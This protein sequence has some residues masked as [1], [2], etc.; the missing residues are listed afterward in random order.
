MARLVVRG[1]AASANRLKG[2]R[3]DDRDPSSFDQGALAEGTRHE[4]EHTDDESMARE[5]AM[6]HLAE[7]P[8]YYRKLKELEKAG[9]PHPGLVLKPSTVDPRVKRWQR[10]SPDAPAE[11]QARRGTG[12]LGVTRQTMESVLGVLATRIGKRD[13][14]MRVSQFETTDSRGNPAEVF[15]VADDPRTPGATAEASVNTNGSVTIRLGVPAPLKGEGW[16]RVWRETTLEQREAIADAMINDPEVRERVL[17]TLAHEIAHAVDA[18]ANDWRASHGERGPYRAVVQQ[19]REGGQGRREARRAA[20]NTSVGGATAYYNTPTEIRATLAEFYQGLLGLNTL[21]PAAHQRQVIDRLRS[22]DWEA[23]V[24]T[25]RDDGTWAFVAA[26]KPTMGQRVLAMMAEQQGPWRRFTALLSR[27]EQDRMIRHV[28]GWMARLLD[29]EDMTKAGRLDRT[30]LVL[31]ASDKNPR[32]RRWQKPPGPANLGVAGSLHEARSKLFNRARGATDAWRLKGRAAWYGPGELLRSL[33]AIEAHGADLNE[34]SLLPPKGW[35]ARPG[36]TE[37]REA[38]VWTIALDRLGLHPGQ[39]HSAAALKMRLQAYLASGRHPTAW[40]TN[41]ARRGKS[42]AHPRRSYVDPDPP[43]WTPQDLRLYHV[44]TPS[45]ARRIEREG[46][47]PGS[48]ATRSDAGGWGPTPLRHG[49]YLTTDPGDILAEIRSDMMHDAPDDAEPVIF[50]VDPEAL[51]TPSAWASDEDYAY[52]IAGQDPKPGQFPEPPWARSLI[53]GGTMAYLGRIHPRHLRRIGTD[54]NPIP[55]GIARPARASI[56]LNKAVVHVKAHTRGGKPV[57]A[58]TR[59]EPDQRV[60]VDDVKPGRIWRVP[61]RDFKST[62]G[63]DVTMSIEVERVDDD[64]AVLRMVY[65]STKEPTKAQRGR[66]YSMPLAS[67][68]LHVHDLQGHVSDVTTASGDPAIDAVIGGKV[69]RAGK[70]HDGVVF[71]TDDEAVK[72]GTTTPYHPDSEGHRTPEEAVEHSRAEYRAHVDLEDLPLVPRARWREHGGRGWLV[73]PRL[74]PVAHEDLTAEDVAQVRRFVGGAHVRGLTVGD[75]IQLGRD[76]DGALYVIDLGQV[77]PIRNVYD[78][79]DDR[80]RLTRIER[81]AGVP[82]RHTGPEAVEA[83][84]AMRPAVEAAIAQA[85]Q[86]DLAPLRA[87]AVDYLDAANTARVHLG[88]AAFETDDDDDMVRLIDESTL[89]GDRAKAVAGHLVPGMAKGSPVDKSRLVLR[90]APTNPRVRRWQTPPDVPADLH[91][92]SPTEV[93]RYAHEHDVVR[94]WTPGAA[95]HGLGPLTMR[96]PRP[97]LPR[98]Q[99]AQRGAMLAGASNPRLVEPIRFVSP[100]HKAV[101]SEAGIDLARLR[102][103]HAYVSAFMDAASWAWDAVPPSK[104]TVAG[105]TPTDDEIMAMAAQHAAEYAGAPEENGTLHLP[106]QEPRRAWAE[107]TRRLGIDPRTSNFVP[108]PWIADTLASGEGVYVHNHPRGGPLSPEDLRVAIRGNLRAMI[109]VAMVD[110]TPRAYVL[111]RTGAVWPRATVEAWSR[112]VRLGVEAGNRAWMNKHGR[113]AT[114]KEAWDGEH[115]RICMEWIDRLARESAGPRKRINLPPGVDYAAYDLP[116]DLAKSDRGPVRG[117]RAEPDRHGGIGGRLGRLVVR[118]LK[119]KPVKDRPGYELRPSDV[120]PAVRRWHKV[121]RRSAFDEAWPTFRSALK[122]ARAVDLDKIERPGGDTVLVHTPDGA[123]TAIQVVVSEDLPSNM[124]GDSTRIPVAHDDGAWTADALVR[125]SAHYLRRLGGGVG[126]GRS[127][128]TPEE[129]RSHIEDS[130]RSLLVHEI[131]HAVDNRGVWDEGEPESA[132]AIA[133][134]MWATFKRE[135]DRGRPPPGIPIKVGGVEVV[136]TVW[137]ADGIDF[138][139]GTP[140]DRYETGLDGVSAARVGAHGGETS[141]GLNMDDPEGSR[142]RLAALV[143]ALRGHVERANTPLLFR[144]YVNSRSE[145]L[146]HAQQILAESLFR[147][148]RI[149]KVEAGDPGDAG[150]P[151]WSRA[152]L[153]SATW[154]EVKDYLDEGHA[155]SIQGA[156]RLLRASEAMAKAAGLVRGYFTRSGRWVP[157]KIRRPIDLP[158]MPG[159]STLQIAPSSPDRVVRDLDPAT[160][161]PRYTVWPANAYVGVYLHPLTFLGATGTPSEWVRTH[162]PERFGR[163]KAKVADAKGPPGLAYLRIEVESGAWRVVDHDGRHRSVASVDAGYQVEPVVLALVGSDDEVDR[164]MRW[165]LSAGHVTVTAQSGKAV[166]LQLREPGGSPWR[167]ST[168]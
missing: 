78:V 141:I 130:V 52:G 138:Y 115:R 134:R 108:T 20:L 157:P 122:A 57:R 97:H 168:T 155:R 40:F 146:A 107:W 36:T 165:A 64:R 164:F 154:R 133:D 15:V 142:G 90:A 41:R 151:L 55:S 149:R 148:E 24:P 83:E 153:V 13:A 81:A 16:P 58:H 35:R 18:A 72:V 31:R 95:E 92:R 61:T 73:K 91:R 49:I 76:A 68:P 110:G 77:R 162:D 33:E 70:G 38:A 161:P 80:S 63:D 127:R 125:V 74:T 75:E 39:R 2:G 167:S 87:L 27:E 120:N 5:I 166:D 144:E 37:E 67:V 86:G 32:V 51:S 22:S 131:T 7:D 56:P 136:V 84:A 117:D 111:K 1:R 112:I 34:I 104:D 98:Y 12:T 156:W 45:N 96:N 121:R 43:L 102:A 9:P 59:G 158:P 89:V 17:T 100:E 103:A 46:L 47:I 109:A 106:G 3:A 99:P 62:A 29:G 129:R 126:F 85:E 93:T 65:G 114:D 4:L 82:P 152:E 25:R 118:L 101:L 8:D 123:T 10:A 137:P 128:R 94:L 21:D 71:L 26:D 135:I 19:Y 113:D 132:T 42:W 124:A 145:F 140:Q 53:S 11:A 79:D 143:M 159:P 54:D 30:R 105:R 23:M 44:T 69:E 66:A 160:L 119:G 50:E 28:G 60:T 150:P 48:R 6:D 14:Y 163:A 139:D 88:E 147:M 116:T